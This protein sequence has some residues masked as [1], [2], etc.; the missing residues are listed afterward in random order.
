[1]LF[2]MGNLKDVQEESYFGLIFFFLPSIS[3][4]KCWIQMPADP[5]SEFGGDSGVGLGKFSWV[6]LLCA[7]LENFQNSLSGSLFIC[8]S[9]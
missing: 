3:D 4:R 7:M 8:F 2:L 1:M 9:F 6:I 5:I